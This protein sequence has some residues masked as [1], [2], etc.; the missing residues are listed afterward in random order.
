MRN[1]TT[2]AKTQTGEVDLLVVEDA[3][4]A[5]ATDLQNNQESYFATFMAQA[6]I[7]TQTSVQKRRKPSKEWKPRK[8]L[9][10]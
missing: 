3:E 1:Q 4:E 9:R 7:I 5:E 6:Q 10:W 8:R 2:T